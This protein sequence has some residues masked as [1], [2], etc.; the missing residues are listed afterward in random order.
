MV[1]PLV[2]TQ[3]ELAATQA[4]LSFLVGRVAKQNSSNAAATTRWVSDFKDEIVRG[5]DNI[6]INITGA[7]TTA[8]E[9]RQLMKDYITTHL[10]SISFSDS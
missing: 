2:R 5:L 6:T 3:I 7:G 1:D 10:G 8:E 4:A 9:A